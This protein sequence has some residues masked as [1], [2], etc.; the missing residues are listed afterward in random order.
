MT[1]NLTQAFSRSLAAVLAAVLLCA[2]LTA[3][4]RYGPPEPHPPD[5]EEREEEEEQP[6]IRNEDDH[7]LPSRLRPARQIQ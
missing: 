1:R 6:G 2:G 7:S 4:G 5:R 3:C